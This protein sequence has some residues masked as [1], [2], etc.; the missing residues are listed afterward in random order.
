MKTPPAV[1]RGASPVRRAVFRLGAIFAL[2]VV[3]WPAS[4]CS[5]QNAGG[6]FQM[7]PAP[8][9]VADVG[10]QTVRDRFQ[11]LGSLE[12]DEI[13]QVV[14][15]LN[16]QV[17]SLPFAEGTAVD[18]GGLIAQLDDSEI[19][20]DA[21]RAEAQREL[22]ELNAERARKL[23]DEGAI[24]TQELDN[25]RT[26]LKV[27]EANEAYAKARFAKTRI[28]AP[29]AGL[30][31]RRRVSNGAYLQAGDIITELARV[32]QMRVA[33]AAPERY[34]PDLARGR[35][36]EITTP[37]YPGRTFKGRVSVVD[38]IVDPNTRTVQIVARV[39]N[40]GRLLRPGLSADVWVTLGERSKALVVPDEAVF[41]E[42]N[43]MF[44]YTVNPDS[45]V[46]RTAVVL[47][48][49][50]SARVEV[51]EGLAAGSVVVRSGHQKLYEGAKVMPVPP[52]P[53]PG[54]GGDAAAATA[55]GGEETQ[56]E[57]KDA[58]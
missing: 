55:G 39:P 45:T 42:G 26:A 17:T 36:V 22:A 1:F 49:R 4:G 11:A 31:G 8:V 21:K 5:G 27:A 7:P 58:P 54:A 48:T 38:P 57:A 12:A 33:F 32:S 29:F 14:S 10:A 16:A 23:A 51:L 6:G 56:A 44:V 30:I 28:R 13:I 37:A 47:G 35:E 43:Q 2:A 15:E 34:L 46:T 3:V 41:A 18:S 24:S 52:G 25:I 40:P 9:E 19:R 50:D 20:A 53:P